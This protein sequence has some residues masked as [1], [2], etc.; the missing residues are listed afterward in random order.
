MKKIIVCLLFVSLLI[1]CCACGNP[2]VTPASNNTTANTTAVQ[3]KDTVTLSLADTA[4]TDLWDVTLR[5]AEMS[6]YANSSSS[7]FGEP[8]DSGSDFVAHTGTVLVIPTCT[9]KNKD[10]ADQYFADDFQGWRI[11]LKVEYKGSQYQLYGFDHSASD[12]SG[13]LFWSGVSRD[14]G[15]TW[16]KHGSANDILD[17]GEIITFRPIL[18]GEFDPDSLND[19]FEISLKIPTSSGEEKEFVYSVH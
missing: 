17:A 6:Y 15:A 8:I 1:S 7:S 14:N 3:A 13:F 12:V 2:A 19:P 4:S 11:S 16:D 10:R 9:V 5:D 18:V